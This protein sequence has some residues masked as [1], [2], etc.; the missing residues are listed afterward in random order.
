MAAIPSVNHQQPARGIVLLAPMLVIA[1][2]I[3]DPGHPLRSHVMLAQ[4]WLRSASPVTWFP[5]DRCIFC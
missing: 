2:A 1:S 4:S 5:S 3:F